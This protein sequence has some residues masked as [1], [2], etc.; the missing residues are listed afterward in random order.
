MTQQ[1]SFIFLYWVFLVCVSLLLNACMEEKN[2]SSKS[3]SFDTPADTYFSLAIT[4]N[5]L[6]HVGARLL[7]LDFQNEADTNSI[8]NNIV[9]A[10]KIENNAIT[11][12]GS[13]ADWNNEFLSTINGLPQNN[14]PLSKFVDATATDITVGAAWDDNYLY[15]FVQWEDA[16]H[17]KSDAYEKWIFGDQGNGESGWNPKNSITATTRAPN[18]S[19]INKNH[20]LAGS[21]NEDRLLILF[22]IIDSE[23]NFTDMGLGCAAYCHANLKQDNPNQNYTGLSVSKM[24]SNGETDIAD[25]WHWQA[26]RTGGVGA[27]D[28]LSIGYTS[29][30]TSG[31]Q[32]DSGAA[33]YVSNPLING[34]PNYMHK[35]GLNV[36]N[37]ILNQSDSIEFNGTPELGHEIPAV[38]S[39]PPSG[40]RADV[41]AKAM[42]DESSNKWTVELRR[43]L[44]TNDE[45]DRQFTSTNAVIAPVNSGI[46][47]VDISLGEI[48]YNENCMGCHQ[49]NGRGSVNNDAWIFP[50]IQRTSGSLILKA[51]KTVSAMSGIKSSLGTTDQEV[52]QAAENIAA[53]L[54]TQATFSETHSVT[55]SVNGTSSAGAITSNVSGINCPNE[56]LLAYSEGTSI[57]LTANDI[58]DMDFQGWGDDCLGSGSNNACSLS[59]DSDKIVT[60][61]YTPSLTYQLN[62]SINGVSGISNVITSNP[63]T[64]NCPDTCSVYL[65]QNSSIS[66]TAN[67]LSGFVFTGWGGVCS[68]ANAIC[69]VVM[70]GDITLTA[71]YSSVVNNYTLSVSSDNGV[72]TDSNTPFGI[73]CGSDCSETIAENSVVTLTATPNTGYSFDNWSGDACNGSSDTNCQ[74]NITANANITA[75]F[76]VIQNPSC[77]NKGVIYNTNGTNGFGLQRMINE[78]II[79]NPTDM[80]FVPSSSTAFMVTA[81]NGTVHYF[82]NSCNATKSIDISDASNSGIG[83]KDGGEQGLLNIEFHPDYGISNQFVFFYHT[84]VSSRVNSISRMTVSIDAADNLILSDAVKIIDFRK[85]NNASNHNGGGL[86]FAPDKTLL[87]SVG[88]GGSNGNSVNAQVNTNLMGAVIRITPSLAVATGGYT[89]PTNNRF[90]ASNPQCTDI[91]LSTA[92]C[93]EILSMGLRNPYRM[94]MENNIIYLGEVGTNYEEI[95]RFDYTDNTVNFGWDTYDGPVNQAGF[96]DPIL[97]Y[98]RSDSTADLFRSEDPDCNNCATG[99]ASVMIGDVYSGSRYDGLLTGK[100]LHAEF[101]DGFVRALGVNATGDTIDNGI[102]IVHHDG[103]S[104]MIEA[105]DGYIYFATQKGAWGTGDADMIYRLVKP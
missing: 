84:S 67:T 16:G 42:Y 60:A 53:Y 55:V 62:I 50:R 18:D 44:I 11:L 22:P 35:D 81:Q 61:T 3:D 30:G 83:V 104:A 33:A 78:N 51:L 103:V 7:F 99:F 105:E 47:A 31:Y 41:L 36:N 1:K 21:E 97:S 19:V 46:T 40:N 34:N 100:L 85:V 27:A 10:P 9:I 28:D 13:D 59:M 26:L 101:M 39:S 69:E 72:I 52:K 79:S 48:L 65:K 66:L 86:V 24:Y 45:N 25:V 87:A 102:H 64:I 73:N 49:S 38:L 37:N 70:T 80:A 63:A 14:Y 77:D 76:S 57:T 43:L 89:I 75:N 88:D 98:R 2:E 90:N 17:T 6:N 12:D 4:E 94:S 74:F 58:A 93:P 71:N 91:S 68:D 29:D 56:C 15:F 32:A 8:Q 92:A 54:Q 82:N 96:Y 95:N 20:D 5:S 23:N